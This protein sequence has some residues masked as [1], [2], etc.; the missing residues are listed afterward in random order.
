M[1]ARGPA[2][3]LEHEV[4]VLREKCYQL[5]VD[6]SIC[7]GVHTRITWRCISCEDIFEW[8]YNMPGESGP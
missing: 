3:E 4:A 7:M 2:G 5:D 6:V 8:A 1:Y